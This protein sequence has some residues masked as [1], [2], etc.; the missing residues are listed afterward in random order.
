MS[1]NNMVVVAVA[2]TAAS[3]NFGKLSRRCMTPSMTTYM[4]DSAPTSVGVKIPVYI[5]VM[6]IIGRSTAPVD[7]IVV[8]ILSF[9][10]IFCCI[11][12][13]ISIL[14]VI[15]KYLL[16]ISYMGWIDRVCG[17]VFG[18]TKGLLISFIFFIAFT[19][20]LP[21]DNTI[22]E[23]SLLAPHLSYVPVKMIKIVNK[24]MKQRFTKNIEG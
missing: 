9:L 18:L 22:M 24:D 7:L 20:F 16:S 8:L 11:F 5:A 17:A 23:K 19:T 13:F 6:M 3:F 10:L 14:G 12:L 2:C 21:K 1:M 15:I 4:T